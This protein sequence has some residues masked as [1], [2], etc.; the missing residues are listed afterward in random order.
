MIASALI[1]FS[2]YLESWFDIIL[3]VDEPSMIACAFL[4]LTQR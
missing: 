4:L 1:D 2:E 3:Y